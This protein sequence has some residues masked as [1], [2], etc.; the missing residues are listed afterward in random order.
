MKGYKLTLLLALVSAGLAFTQNLYS[1]EVSNAPTAPAAYVYVQTLKGVN[2]YDAAANG[3]LTLVPGSPF[4][5]VGEMIGS[6]RKYFFSL[7][8]YWVHSYP[9]DAKGRIGAQAD[10]ID[11]QIY[12]SVGCGPTQGA[13]LDHTGQNLYVLLNGNQFEGNYNGRAAYQTYKIAKSS[14][15][16][17]FN[18]AA[19][20]LTELENGTQ[21]PT[22]TGDDKFAY[23]ID[24]V[25]YSSPT[26]A[27]FRHTNDGTLIDWSFSETDPPSVANLWTMAEDPTNHLAIAFSTNGGAPIASYTVDS[28]GNL[29]STNTAEEVMMS[30]VWPNTMNMSPSG[31]FLAV[32]SQTFSS[33][34][35]GVQIFRFNGAA[36]IKAFSPAL[37]TASID[38]IHWDNN[39]HLYA[40]SYATNQ[41]FVF[42]VTETGATQAPGSPYAVTGA[43]GHQ[44]LI[45]VPKL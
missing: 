10:Q 25:T 28:Q 18:G 21:L 45:V 29:S 17:M 39:G 37:T 14:G 32:A 20:I 31:K 26:M 2:L 4:A 38:Q 36:P 30:D 6:N 7:G 3:T 33:V 8:T 43:Y 23:A 34:R 11:T 16:L 42:A 35:T 24:N 41:L 9:V 19:N 12:D 15:H 1:Q 22:I 13:V 40:L 27:G 5:T 44:G